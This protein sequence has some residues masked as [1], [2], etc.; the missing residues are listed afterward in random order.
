MVQLAT[1]NMTTNGLLSEEDDLISGLT[2]EELEEFNE[3]IDDPDVSF[4]QS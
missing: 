4:I 1:E 3:A 2:K